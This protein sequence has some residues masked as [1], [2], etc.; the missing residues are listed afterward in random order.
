M[1]EKKY[2]RKHERDINKKFEAQGRRL[3]RK[4]QSK[5]VGWIVG[6]AILI[7]ALQFTPYRDIP[8]DIVHLAINTIQKLTSGGSG[9]GSGGEP[10]PKYW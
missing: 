5:T 4:W 3:K 2:D 10:D 9:G 1:D 7:G 6:L 8:M